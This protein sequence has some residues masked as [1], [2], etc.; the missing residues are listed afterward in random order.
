M[1]MW[2]PSSLVTW[3]KLDH[4]FCTQLHFFL[5]SCS[6]ASSIFGLSRLP[7]SSQSHTQEECCHPLLWKR[8]KSMKRNQGAEAPLLAL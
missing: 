7:S 1:E 3:G 5:P 6:L 8:T 2:L 4:G